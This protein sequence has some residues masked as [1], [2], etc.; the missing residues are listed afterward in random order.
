M[1]EP[2]QSPLSQWALAEMEGKDSY[3]NIQANM[4]VFWDEVQCLMDGVNK[5]VRQ[6]EIQ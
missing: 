1:K 6:G 4:K 5:R 3:S 2:W